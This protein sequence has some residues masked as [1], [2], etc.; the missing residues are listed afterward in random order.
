MK[1]N[2]LF[3]WKKNAEEWNL[4]VEKELIPSRKFTNKAIVDTLVS[5]QL[6]KVAD[7]GC[8]EGWLTRE[9]TKLGITAH[10]FDATAELIQFAQK[11]GPEAYHI[12]SF[13]RIAEG[14]PLPHSP[15]DG[16]VFNFSLY[17]K[18]HTAPLLQRTLECL[19]NNGI[20]LI[21]TLHPFYL[22]E[23]GFGYQSQWLSN[24]WEGLSGNFSYGHPWYAR[25]LQDWIHLLAQIPNTSF[26]VQEITN[27]AKRPV[28]LLLILKKH[29]EN[30]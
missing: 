18:D 27:D 10:G 24:S 3:S 21:Q 26:E 28:S 14:E 19:T 16:A 17:L 8:G 7:L 30:N 12:L 15:Y 1:S 2:I 13:E 22:M 23:N 11:K 4:V 5:S 9:M 6:G 20:L 25:T 29:Y